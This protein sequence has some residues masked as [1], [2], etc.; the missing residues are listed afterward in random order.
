VVSLLVVV[1]LVIVFVVV[2]G[3]DRPITGRAEATPA[4]Q[5]PDDTWT[6][7][8]N[9]ASGLSYQIPPSLWTPQTN[10]GTDGPV[11]LRNGARRTAYTCGTPGQEYVR[12][13]LGSGTAPAAGP[14]QVATALAYTAASQYYSSGSQGPRISVDPA[15]PVQRRTPSGKT[16]QGAVVR[17]IATQNADKCL[18]DRGEVLVLVLQ[19]TDSDAVLVVNGDLSGGPATP[20]PPTEDELR[21]ILDSAVPI[22]G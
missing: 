7:L 11:N 4:D 21:K 18:A 6:T 10:D 9:A 19:L 13:E 16:V 17:A 3:G 5:A 2:N 22:A 1:G 14:D 8:R 15:Q 12:G 20:A